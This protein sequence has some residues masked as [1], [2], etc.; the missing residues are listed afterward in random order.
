MYLDN[1]NNEA[2]TIPGFF[3]ADA[4][5]N[6]DM[7]TFAKRGEY[8]LSILVNNFT[9]SRYNFNGTPSHYFQQNGAN[10]IRVATPNYFPAAGINYYVSLTMKF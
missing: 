8:V 6:F 10:E 5:L 9:D 7:S 2:L 1:T 3:F 4:R